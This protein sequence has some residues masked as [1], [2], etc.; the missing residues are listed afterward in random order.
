MGHIAGIHLH[1][2]GHKTP[3]I[4]GVVVRIPPVNLR[5]TGCKHSIRRRNAH[6]DLIRQCDSPPLVPTFGELVGEHVDPRWRRVVR[7]MCG[8][9]GIIDQEGLGRRESLL[10][11]DPVDRLVRQ[12]RVEDVVGIADIRLDRGRPF[13]NCGRPLA[14]IPT[15]EAIEMLEAQG[16]GP[17]IEGT[18][19][20]G[21]PIGHIMVL[22]KPGR[23]ESAQAQY[24][25]DGSR[26]LAH[27]SVVARIPR[28]H[29]R[30]ATGV[31]RMVVTPGNQC[32]AG[33]RTQSR[34]VKLSIA[35][36]PSGQTIEVWRWY[37]SAERTG[38]AKTGV[39][40]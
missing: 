30:D 39:I 22:A 1:H 31:G 9:W 11:L 13:V 37:G 2:V 27:Q 26:I 6:S 17:E 29:L 38:S 4:I 40:Q 25:A 28:G 3:V 18:G 24:L 36:S 35:Q 23:I 32:G 20:A 19:L 21:L 10:L 14:G 12:V 33:W 34:G 5:R 16:S 8:S 7:G 15:D